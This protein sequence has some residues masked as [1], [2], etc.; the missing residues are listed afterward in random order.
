MFKD[1]SSE[2]GFSFGLVTGIITTLGAIV[3]LYS[4]TNSI[5]PII[6][7]IISIGIADAFS[8]SLGIHISEESRTKSGE[9]IWKATIS[10]FFSKLFFAFSFL[11]PILV[12][13]LPLSIVV[14]SIYGISLIGIYSYTLQKKKVKKY[15]AIVEHILIAVLTI[16]I[17]Y[18]VGEFL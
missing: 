16:I 13:P 7:A 9:K 1:K 18:L 6:A 12:F 10:T 5:T 17:I 8:D 3:G 14:S 11:I 4:S 2:R 15:K